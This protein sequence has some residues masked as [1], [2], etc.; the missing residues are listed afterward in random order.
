M[1]LV[2]QAAKLKTAYF[3]F[4]EMTNNEN[5]KSDICE[6]SN[7]KFTNPEETTNLYLYT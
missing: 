6:L 1:H 7:V 4:C 5:C 2:V 3:A